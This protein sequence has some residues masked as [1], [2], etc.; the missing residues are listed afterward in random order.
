MTDNI[1]P[2]IRKP[3]IGFNGLG[4]SPLGVPNFFKVSMF[5]HLAGIARGNL[6]LRGD[7]DLERSMRLV[8]EESKE[9]GVAYEKYNVARTLENLVPLVDAIAD[10]EYVLHNLSYELGTNSTRIFDMVHEANMRKRVLCGQCAGAGCL[11]CNHT[12]SYFLKNDAGK[13]IKPEGW[14]GPEGA[15]FNH[16]YE[17]GSKAYAA[18]HGGDT[19]KPPRYLY[20]PVTGE[21]TLLPEG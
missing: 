6:H 15:I 19:Q 3:S 12:G 7:V 18:Y 21:T 14:Q 2:Y 4:T 10:L 5:L 16:L 11:L 9:L 17:E 20:D 8:R 13:V 1:T